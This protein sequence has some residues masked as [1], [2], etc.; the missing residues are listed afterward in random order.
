MDVVTRGL[1][2][3]EVNYKEGDKILTVLAEGQGK[4]TVKA[5]GCR[6]KNS[7]LAA[8]AQLLVFSDM[9]LS[10]Y[11]DRWSLRE[12][13]TAEEFRGLRG[14]LEKLALGTYFAEV[15]E[16][17]AE[18][19]VETPG[20]LSLVLNSLYALDKLGKPQSL[21]K[22]AFEM[23]LACLVGY[24]PLLDACAVCGEENPEKPGLDLSAGVLHCGRCRRELEGEGI[25]LPLDGPTLAALRYIVYGDPKRLFSFQ[26]PQ[27]SL[28]QLAGVTESFLLT[29]L[30][31]GFR[32]LDFYKQMTLGR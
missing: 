13:A 32:T 23:K 26:L 10:D 17:V 21:V 14:D 16:A 7:P 1:V 2:L 11:Q 22:A 4:R 12:A 20:L 9:T 24:E 31:R 15:A 8:G 5:A 30:E 3:R 25:S 19:G 18:E 27:E 29:Q 28:E 6:R